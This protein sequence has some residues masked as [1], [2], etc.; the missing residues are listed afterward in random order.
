MI[1]YYCIDESGDIGYTKK[2]TRFFILTIVEVEDLTILR[3]LAKDIHSF[4]KNKYR[5]SVL[6][7]YKETVIV[8]RKLLKKLAILNDLRCIAIV[9]DRERLNVKDSYMFALKKFVELVSKQGTHQVIVSRLDTRKSYNL[10]IIDLFKKYNIKLTF[11]DPRK[12]K[13]LQIVDFYSWCIFTY[14]EKNNPE[15]FLK[16]KHQVEIV[17]YNNA[18]EERVNYH[19]DSSPSG[20]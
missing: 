16:L 14:F 19:V 17:I 2:S 3:R 8:K 1:K 13:A 11:L 7:T 15:Y 4:K 20:V 9:L 12:E 10:K 6:H 5:D 18:P